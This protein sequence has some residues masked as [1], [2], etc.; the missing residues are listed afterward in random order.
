MPPGSPALRGPDEINK[1][2]TGMTGAYSTPFEL[3]TAA[4][5]GRGDLAISTGDYSV[6]LTP[7]QKG[8]KPLPTEEG[9]YL[10]VMKK[11]PDGSWRLIYDMWN[12][13]AAPKP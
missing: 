9:K 10:G 4:V 13:N 8:A 12:T 3:K 11:Q 1:F 6:T 7:K 2:F 5:E